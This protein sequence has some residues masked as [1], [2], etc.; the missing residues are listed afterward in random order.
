[1]KGAASPL[2]TFV[3]LR[4]EVPELLI[5][6]LNFSI[7][8]SGKEGMNLLTEIRTLHPEIPVILL[9]GWGTIDLAVQGMKLGARD[10]I[11]KP[12]AKRLPA[13]IGAAP[14]SI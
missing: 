1:M 12:L 10:F 4:E 13:A 11:T 9:T 14:S 5:L 6:D 2:E 8:T 7:E 3:L